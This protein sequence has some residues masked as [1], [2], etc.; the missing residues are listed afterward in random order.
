MNIQQALNQSLL[1]IA[2]GADRTG[3]VLDKGKQSAIDKY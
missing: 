2:I 1:A 3:Q